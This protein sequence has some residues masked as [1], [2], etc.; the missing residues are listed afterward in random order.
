MIPTKTNIFAPKGRDYNTSQV[1]G[2]GLTR[3]PVKHCRACPHFGVCTTSRDG[4][5]LSA[6]EKN[7]SGSV[8]KMFTI[9]LQGQ[10]VYRLRKQKAELPFGHIKRNLGAGQFLLRGKKGVDAE[11]SLLST[12]FNV[13]RMMTI[14][15]IPAL[16]LKLQ[17]M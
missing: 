3:P 4:R 17:G 9:A 16:I 15:G 2:R 11:L 6:W 8:L 12:C 10:A 5:R 1:P 13:A 14:I 7:R